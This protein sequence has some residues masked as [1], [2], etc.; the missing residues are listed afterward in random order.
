MRVTKDPTA[1][2]VRASL[3]RRGLSQDD[4]ASHLGVSRAYVYRRVNGFVP[5]T[6]QDLRSIAAFVEVPLTSLLSPPT[7][8]A[9][10]AAPGGDLSSP[11]SS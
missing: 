5:F 8:A 6:I 1:G 11:V 10:P 7:V 3:A 9:S 2:E 4:L